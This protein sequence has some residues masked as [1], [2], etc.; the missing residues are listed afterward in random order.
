M[1]P[2]SLNQRRA[3][4]VF[5]VFAFAYFLSTLVR[6]I[7]ATLSPTLVDEFGL[8]ARELGLLAGGYFLGF[9][10]TQLPMGHWLDRYGPKRVLMGFLL[11]AVVGSAAFAMATGFSGLLMAR[12]LTGVGVS[13]CLM[14]PLTGY[15]RWMDPAFQLRANSWML[16]TGAL[17]M[18]CSTLPVQWLLPVLGWRPL[19]W[20][21]AG[22]TVLAVLLI[23]WVV[24]R[25]QGAPAAAP[26]S[27][28]ASEPA[29]PPQ[30]D[31]GLWASYRVVWRHPYFRRMVP[32]GVITYGGMLAMQTLWAGPWLVRVSGYSPLEAATGLFTLNAFMLVTFWAWGYFNPRLAA[33]GWSADRVITWGAPLN[34]LALL[35]L[36]Y[37]GPE[38]GP[39]TWTLF[40]MT[41]SCMSLAQPA[42]GMAF[43]PAQAGR[44]LSG[45]NLVMFSGVFAAQWG[46]GLLIDGFMRLDWTVVASFQGALAVYGV[47]SAIAYVHFLRRAGDN[48]KVAP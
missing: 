37:R 36:I 19:F 13:A 10:A 34:L 45:Y 43:P 32:L 20:V 5:V 8:Q 48:D 28:P 23:G 24:P 4:A 39:L 1:S 25:W 26:A 30:G 6:A 42:V 3:V 12:I 29:S 9:A 22:L 2:H 11:V 15:R 16:M 40:C 47:L 18:L 17:G 33:A 41:N 27:T 21:L 14:A 46:I 35:F 38:A 7:T 44:A 31:T